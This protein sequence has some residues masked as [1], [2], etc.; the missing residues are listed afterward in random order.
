MIVKMGQLQLLFLLLSLFCY[1]CYFNLLLNLILSQEGK[2][3]DFLKSI[4]K[5]NKDSLNIEG[6]IDD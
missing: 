3:V 5:N 4:R 1:Y 6:G 2:R